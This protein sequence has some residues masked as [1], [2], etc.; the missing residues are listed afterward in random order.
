MAIFA[1]AEEDRDALRRMLDNFKSGNWPST[2]DFLDYIANAI[3]GLDRE[4]SIFGQFAAEVP[5]RDANGKCGEG[6]LTV[7]DLVREGQSD[8]VL[9]ATTRTEPAYNFTGDVLEPNKFAL[10]K[11]HYKSGLWIVTAFD[12]AE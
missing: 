5:A 10:A 2:D 4:D 9:K 7:W 6:L 3:A 11:R 8:A 12:C 1:I